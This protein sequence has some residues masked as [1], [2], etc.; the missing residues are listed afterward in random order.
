MGC[1]LESALIGARRGEVNFD[2]GS[3]QFQSVMEALQGLV[4]S[5]VDKLLAR[6][7]P[8]RAE[9]KRKRHLRSMLRDGCWPY[10]RTLERLML[11]TGT[12]KE[13]SHRP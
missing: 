11:E 13:V 10:A 9:R 5:L 12:T 2:D 3:T 6:L 1:S 8:P 4:N 7:W